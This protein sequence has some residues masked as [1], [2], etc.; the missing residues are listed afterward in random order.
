MNKEFAEKVKSYREANN[1]TMAEF[2][3]RIGV[4]EGTVSLW[5]SGKTVP[6]QTTISLIDKV[7]GGR[8][9]EPA[10]R[11]HLDLMKEV[12][13]TVEEIFQ[14]DKLYLP[15]KKKAELLILLYE[16]VIEGKTTRK[17]LEGRVLSLIKLAS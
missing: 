2:A 5:E 8:E 10:G 7:F 6:R 17:D 15:P 16:E 11:L 4:S 9:Q 14:K 12:I 1:M 3:K 13:Q